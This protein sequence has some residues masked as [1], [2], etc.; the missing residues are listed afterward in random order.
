MW[1]TQNFLCTTG[2]GTV[3]DFPLQPE[4]WRFLMTKES[5]LGTTTAGWMWALRLPYLDEMPSRVKGVRIL[6]YNWAED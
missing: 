4:N 1:I 2:P 5:I 6:C 3:R